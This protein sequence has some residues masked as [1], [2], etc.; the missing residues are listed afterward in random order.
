M[1]RALRLLPLIALLTAPIAAHSETKVAAGFVMA[2]DFIPLFVAA[3]QGFMKNHG[4]DVTPTPVQYATNAPAALNAGSIQIGMTTVPI[5]AQARQGGLDLVAIC[6]LSW[7]TRANPQLSLLVRPNSGIKTA[8]DLE[9]R[10]VAVPGLN[11]LFDIAAQ[12][13]VQVNG[14]DRKKVNFVEVPMPQL[15][16]V[17]RGGSVDAIA[18]ID[19]FRAKALSDGTAVKLA[20]YL[21]DMRDNQPLAFWIAERGWVEKNKAA[22]PAYCAA[23]DDAL[24]WIG[25]HPEETRQI[26]AKWLHGQVIQNF[27]NWST[28]LSPEDLALQIDIAH[29]MGFLTEPFN[30]QAAVWK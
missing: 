1:L 18:V 15:T 11:S 27:A 8:K 16:D 19:P 26:G 9:G 28:Q 20:D 13:W 10:K 24:A 17:L 5:F 4:L 23:M 25:T 21:A 6:G 29:E 14:A 2:G 30:L 7:E 22:I 12:K 3:D